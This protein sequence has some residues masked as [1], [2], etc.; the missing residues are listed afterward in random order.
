M[1]TSKDVA[2]EANVSHMTV[3]RAF[4]PDSSI[5]EETRKKVL[6]VA[7]KL[8]YIPNY[9]A[10][11]LV[12]NRNFSVGLFFSSMEGTSEVFLG[13]LVSQIYQ[14]L[15]H[16]YLLSVNSV[17]RIN[18]T[19]GN[20][21]LIQSIIGRFDGIII[22]TQSEKDDS[23]IDYLLKLDIPII[24]M[25]RHMEREDI[26][27]VSTNES[28]GI[29]DLVAHLSERK[30]RT[31]GTIK[32]FKGFYS[33]QNRHHEFVLGC[34]QAGIEVIDAAIEE[35]LYNIPSGYEAMKTIIQRNKILPDI[36]F[37]GND[38]MAI[39][40]IKACNELDIQVPKDLSI[41]GFDDTSYAQYTS[42]A[43]TTVHKPYKEMAKK[44]ME[45]LLQLMSGNELKERKYNIDSK[46][47]VRDS[48]KISK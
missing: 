30:I 28:V 47:I 15:P 31:A 13:D 45:I 25:N 37:C 10:K 16:N 14:L 21:Y 11:S 17:D 4:Q 9:N 29:K 3:S 35:G 22:A 24:V 32:G 8:N 40:A 23:F 46:L 19:T 7:R 1:V 36:V 26:Y 5:K 6:A 2:K 27:N 44:S 48:V 42:P 12:M 20:A 38:D 34:E 41:V 18:I 43:L 39:G 33:S